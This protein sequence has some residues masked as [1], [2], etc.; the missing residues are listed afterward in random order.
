MTATDRERRPE[1]IGELEAV[2]RQILAPDFGGDTREAITAALEQVATSR[3]DR[4]TH[5]F[6]D[7]F[8]DAEGHDCLS[9]RWCFVCSQQAQWRASEHE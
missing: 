5:S 6:M 4:F 9:N 1:A 3:G 2:A 7:L 8:L